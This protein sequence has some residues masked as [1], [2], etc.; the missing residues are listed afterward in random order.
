MAVALRH[1]D[2]TSVIGHREFHFLGYSIGVGFSPF[3]NHR[4]PLADIQ[5]GR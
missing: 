4:L 5:S 1:N 3:N 2:V